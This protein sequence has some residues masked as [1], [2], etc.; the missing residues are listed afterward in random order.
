MSLRQLNQTEKSK[1]A[2]LFTSIPTGTLSGGF[3]LSDEVNITFESEDRSIGRS[4]IRGVGNVICF[5][6]ELSTSSRVS[7]EIYQKIQAGAYVQRCYGVAQ[8]DGVFYAVMEDTT[9]EETLAGA[10]RRNALPAA[11]LERV[12]LAYDLSKT[13][14]WYHRAEMLLKSISDDTIILKRLPSGKS[15]TVLTRLENARHVSTVVYPSSVNFVSK[16][17]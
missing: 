16:R 2:S 17:R 8:R 12:H 9:G 5:R 11:V 13:V 4:Y 15:C 1:S 14:A 10:C 3:P 6:T 7:L